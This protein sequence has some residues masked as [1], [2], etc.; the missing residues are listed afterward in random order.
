MCGIAGQ[1]SLTS[2]PASWLDAGLSALQHRGPDASGIWCSSDGRVS[3]GHRRLAVVDLSPKGIQP[4]RRKDF[5]ITFNGEI[6]NAIQLRRQLSSLG[7]HFCSRS[8]TEVI[9]AAYEVWGVAVRAFGGD[10]AL[11]YTTLMPALCIYARPRRKPFFYCYVDS[12]SV[13][14]ELKGLLVDSTLPRRIG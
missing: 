13:T 9:L 5:C 4:M 8:D 7:V 2:R 1:I 3:F 11:Q 6:Y 12:L 14:S 10:V